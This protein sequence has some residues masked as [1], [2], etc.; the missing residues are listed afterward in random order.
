MAGLR[1]SVVAAARGDRH[2]TD[3]PVFGGPIGR[4]PRVSATATVYSAPTATT[5]FG[6]RNQVDEWL[7]LMPEREF[8]IDE[9]Y[10]LEDFN[11]VRAAVRRN[12]TG[13]V[14]T[15]YGD[16]EMC[17][18]GTNYLHVRGG[19]IVAEFAEYDELSLYRQTTGK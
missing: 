12:L 18:M 9:S 7:R 8:R 19:E 16:R 13:T 14:P 11:L 3:D 6:I 17:V 10:W 2:R 5:P 4:W 1:S 15:S